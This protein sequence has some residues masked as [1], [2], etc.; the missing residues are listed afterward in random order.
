MT[1]WILLYKN[2]ALP[3]PPS[4]PPAADVLNLFKPLVSC[5]YRHL[6]HSEPLYIS[7]PVRL[8]ALHDRHD[9]QR[10]SLNINRL[11]VMLFTV[12]QKLSFFTN[13]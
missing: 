2:V 8:F 10:L 1:L 4:L 5:V 6:L 7:K 9:K 12:R 3:P 11:V 13:T